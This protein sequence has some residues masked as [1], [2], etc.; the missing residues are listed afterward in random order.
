M[1]DKDTWLATVQGDWVNLHH[2]MACWAC[3]ERRDRWYN[4]VTLVGGVEVRLADTYATEEEA[5]RGFMKMIFPDH[6]ED[7][8]AS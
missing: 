8:I 6:L 5:Q 3:D 2:V 1:S 7:H 4:M